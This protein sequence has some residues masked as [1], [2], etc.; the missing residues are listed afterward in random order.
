[1]PHSTKSD[2]HLSYKVAA[3]K[4]LNFQPSSTDSKFPPGTRDRSDSTNATG[5]KTNDDET[6]LFETITM[7]KFEKFQATIFPIVEKNHAPREI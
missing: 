7:T 3:S 1:M 2:S 4:N 5:N 6:M